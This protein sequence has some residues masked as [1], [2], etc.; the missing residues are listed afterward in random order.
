[1]K[2][3]IRDVG[4]VADRYVGGKVSTRDGGLVTITAA[5]H[6]PMGHGDTDVVM[7]FENGECVR[8]NTF[9]KGILLKN[10]MFLGENDKFAFYPPKDFA[11][12]GI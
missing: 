12:K 11:A 3:V 1:M 10:G 8:L 7:K 4:Q 2:F 9:D 6:I 5:E